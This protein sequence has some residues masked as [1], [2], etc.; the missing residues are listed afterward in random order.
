MTHSMVDAFG[1]VMTVGA[2]SAAAPGMVRAV[3]RAAAV[4]RSKR[5][6]RVMGQSFETTLGTPAAH[7]GPPF[8][9]PENVARV[10]AFLDQALRR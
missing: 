3:S 5:I 6:V 7:G 4:S 9:S 2:G 1:I 8:S 10:Q